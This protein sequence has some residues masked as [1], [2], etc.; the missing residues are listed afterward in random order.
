MTPPLPAVRGDTRIMSRP[1]TLTSSAAATGTSFCS[2]AILAADRLAGDSRTGGKCLQPVYA[3]Q[4]GATRVLTP[5]LRPAISTLSWMASALLWPLLASTVTLSTP[6][7]VPLPY[8][9]L[10]R[11]SGYALTGSMF[12]RYN[13]R[14]S[15]CPS[16][17]L[18]PPRRPAG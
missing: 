15:G 6:S 5:Q 18:T 14:P 8:G 9:A 12:Q 11:A 1:R 16:R 3:N 10:C 13:F 2:S 17:A 4:R 7:R